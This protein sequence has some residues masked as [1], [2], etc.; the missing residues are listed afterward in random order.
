MYVIDI[1][2]F[3]VNKLSLRDAICACRPGSNLVD[4]EFFFKCHGADHRADDDDQH[5]TEAPPL[6]LIRPNIRQVRFGMSLSEHESYL[7]VLPCR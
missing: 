2:D 6:H 3:V 1:F 5:V 4:V 7:V